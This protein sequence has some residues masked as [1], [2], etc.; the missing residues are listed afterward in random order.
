MPGA[1]EL[2]HQLPTANWMTLVYILVLIAARMAK[3]KLPAW[4]WWSTPLVIASLLL[5]QRRAFWLAAVLAIALLILIGS[6]RTGRDGDGQGRC[7]PGS[8][9][10][11]GIRCS[12]RRADRPG[13]RR[14]SARDGRKPSRQQTGA[15]R[16]CTTAGR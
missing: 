6:G 12:R 11:P 16:P 4:V 13:C 1:D 8:R 2:I 7:K 14:R 9:P 5:S 3:A 10:R 15:G